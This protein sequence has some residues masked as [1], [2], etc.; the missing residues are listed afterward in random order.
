M[1]VKEKKKQIG[2]EKL[3][4]DL[5]VS[6]RVIELWESRQSRPDV[7]RL[8]HLASYFGVTV[9]FL[10]GR[11]DTLGS[12]M[13]INEIAEKT[14]L[15]INAVQ[16]LVNI[17]QGNPG[18]PHATPMLLGFLI[19]DDDARYCLRRL[20]KYAN[21]E[22]DSMAA[23]N[24]LVKE[25]MQSEI[26]EENSKL[27]ELTQKDL[28]PEVIKSLCLYEISMQIKTLADKWTVE[29]QKSIELWEPSTTIEK[30]SDIYG[31]DN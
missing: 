11:S 21:A 5:N 20:M 18:F 22:F 24:T 7:D 12:S 6:K 16:R 8:P 27:L 1:L 26:N 2:K 14:G 28:D 31:N 10:V 19:C 15:P 17:T 13:E 23:W 4:N 30:G 3:S 9:D 25:L 29:Y